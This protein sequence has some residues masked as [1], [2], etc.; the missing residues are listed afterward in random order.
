MTKKAFAKKIKRAIEESGIPQ[1]DLA[2]K[3]KV[4]PQQISKWKTG[5]TQPTLENFDGLLGLLSRDANYFFDISGAVGDKNIVASGKN[6][7]AISADVE[8]LKKE[9]EILKLQNKLKEKK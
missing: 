9:I 6:A 3:L 2:R 7:S 5:E 4:K 8:L 1:K